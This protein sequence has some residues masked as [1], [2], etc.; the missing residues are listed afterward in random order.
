MPGMDTN[1]AIAHAI[2]AALTASPLA[3]GL[4]VALL[5][6]SAAGGRLHASSDVDV[7][8]V[9]K[10]RNISLRLEL[11]L[12]ADLERAC[13]RPVDLVRL[14]VTDTL[15]RWEAAR[16]GRVLFESPPGAA[17][18]FR[19]EAAL[20]HADIAPLIEEGARRWRR[21]VLARSR[22]PG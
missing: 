7:G 17:A 18:R 22:A 5:F 6:G 12:Q 11:E 8:I 4:H 15:V 20:E 1:D 2:S 16:S 10:D 14:D 9:P 13:R 3:A 19:A 21:A